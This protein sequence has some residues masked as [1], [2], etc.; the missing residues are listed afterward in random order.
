MIGIY[1]H[2][3]ERGNGYV[4]EASPLF[5]SPYSRIAIRGVLEGHHPS[6]EIIIPFPLSRGRGYRG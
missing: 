2:I 3:K 6:K 4:R 1:I 5:N